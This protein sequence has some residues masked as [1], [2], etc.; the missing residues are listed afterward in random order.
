MLEFDYEKFKF[1][2]RDCEKEKKEKKP[3]KKFVWDGKTFFDC[4]LCDQKFKRK[5]SLSYHIKSIH[6]QIKPYKCHLCGYANARRMAVT[7]HFA[8]E[9]ER[10]DGKLKFFKSKQLFLFFCV[11]PTILTSHFS[12]SSS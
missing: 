12:V 8:K 10:N 9:H 7:L 1:E 6:D 5:K 2:S 11:L 3:P 4:E